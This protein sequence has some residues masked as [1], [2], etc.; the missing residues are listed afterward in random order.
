MIS[1]YTVRLLF[2]QLPGFGKIWCW[3]RICKVPVAPMTNI[4]PMTKV[5][6]L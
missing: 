4:T 2:F 3:Q 6:G 5:S 1:I